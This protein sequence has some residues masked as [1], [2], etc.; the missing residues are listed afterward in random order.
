MKRIFFKICVAVFVL[1]VFLV[2]SFVVW[3]ANLAH[4]VNAK[5]AAIRA[6]GLPTSGAELN[7]Y[8]PAVPDSENAALV[9]TQVFGLMQTFPDSRSNEVDHF[10][11]P[12][13]GEFPTSEQKHIFASYV[14]MNSAA[15]AK[16]REA[17]KL[18]K[19]RYPIDFSLGMDCQLPH[20]SKLRDLARMEEYTT[21]LELESNDLIKADASI[22]NI[23]GISRTLDYEPNTISW[24]VRI[25]T[26]SI[27]VAMVERR[28]NLGDGDELELVA[29][30]SGFALSEKTNLLARTLIADRAIK[31]RYFHITWAEIKRI[32]EAS[33]DA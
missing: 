27:A 10:R 21:L 18:P 25:S 9:M 12:L 22:K 13:R 24:L 17:I 2:I 33:G 6:A 11:I 29:L 31:M 20:L 19:S 26:I 1:F 3:R 28:L 15:L 23:L 7:A 30:A 16:M 14:E 32:S 4:D 5:L 8:Y